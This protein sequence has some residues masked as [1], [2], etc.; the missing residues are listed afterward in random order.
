MQGLCVRLFND[1]CQLTKGVKKPILKLIG[2][3]LIY[4]NYEIY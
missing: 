4:E 3:S 2:I 1:S